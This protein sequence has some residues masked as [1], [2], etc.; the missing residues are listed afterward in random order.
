MST[1]GP[2]G[3][4]LEQPM[5]DCP[6]CGAEYEDFDGF[7]VVFCPACKFCRHLSRDKKPEGWVCGFCGDV[8]QDDEERA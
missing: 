6:R 5:M 7:G 4:T 2:A 3:E 8:R 1:T